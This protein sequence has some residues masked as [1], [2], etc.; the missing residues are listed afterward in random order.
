MTKDGVTETSSGAGAASGPQLHGDDDWAGDGGRGYVDDEVDALLLRAHRGPVGQPRGRRVQ[1]PLTHRKPYLTGGVDHGVRGGS[2]LR[3]ADPRCASGAGDVG[4]QRPGAVDGG[5]VDLHPIRE[6]LEG[7][8]LELGD[9][10]GRGGPDVEEEV[11]A[12]GH[13]VGEVADD[14]RPVEQVGLVLD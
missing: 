5:G 4:R 8:A 1:G 2:G 11:A 7:A 13:D 3:P 6:L 14:A 9:L 10:A 12:A